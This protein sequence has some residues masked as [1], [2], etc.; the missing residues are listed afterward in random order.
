MKNIKSN[1]AGNFKAK[2]QSSDD[3][4]S[5]SFEDVRE[6]SE[7]KEKIPTRNAKDNSSSSDE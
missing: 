6:S 1:G 3:D 4:S 5:Q 7:Q 2:K